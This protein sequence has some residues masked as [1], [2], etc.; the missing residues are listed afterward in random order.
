MKTSLLLTLCLLPTPLTFAQTASTP[1]AYVPTLTFDVISIKENHESIANG[2]R[3][4]GLNLPH[5]GTIHQTNTKAASLISLAYGNPSH[6]TGVP[7]IFRGRRYDVD[8]KS[9]DATNANAKLA[10]L[11]N[12][13]ARLEKQHMLQVALAQHFKLQVH[14]VTKQEDML[15]LTVTKSGPK[16]QHAEPK[17]PDPEIATDPAKPPPPTLYQSG[18]DPYE[19]HCEGCTMQQFAGL[20]LAL[21][22]SKGIDKTGLTG[23][24]AFVI[25]YHGRFDDVTGPVN[26][27]APPLATVLEDQLGLKVEHT[28]GEVQTLVVDHME[29][30]SEN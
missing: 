28:K 24:Y 18:G 21:L 25:K 15:A 5:S 16:F 19:L 11:S 7:D 13:N 30:P 9:D 2:I 20:A 17:T 12:E 26:V 8:G 10:A 14:F 27:S 3:V 22:G 1:T 4:G 29:L 6:I 23:T